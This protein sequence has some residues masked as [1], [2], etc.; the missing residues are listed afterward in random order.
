MQRLAV[1]IVVGIAVALTVD[2]VMAQ[3]AQY[4]AQV[5]QMYQWQLQH[6]QML[7]ARFRLQ[8]QAGMQ[9]Q[10]A[11]RAAEYRIRAQMQQAS[12]DHLRD[13][14]RD[15]SCSTSSAAPWIR[16]QS[17]DRLQDQ[18]R[19]GT[20]KTS[21]TPQSFTATPPRTRTG[22]SNETGDGIFRRPCDRDSQD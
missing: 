8:Q 7:Q 2:D 3:N 6:Q 17:R 19:D 18:K 1:T 20:C 4:R 11:A 12:R 21:T 16:Q 10:A 15:G 9:G 13:R 22:E 14:L 5:A